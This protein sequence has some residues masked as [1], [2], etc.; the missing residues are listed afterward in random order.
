MIWII[1]IVAA[2]AGGGCSP[3]HRSVSETDI[4]KANKH[5]LIEGID[6]PR[7]RGASGCGSQA[8]GAMIAFANPGGAGLDAEAMADEL[9][10]H[11]EGATPVDLLLAA[12][13]R[14]CTAVIARGTIEALK[15]SIESGQ[16]IL[17]MLDAGLEVRSM[18]LGIRYPT[19]KVMHWAVVSGVAID[20]SQVLLAA[21]NRRHYIAS[22]ED[23]TRR[24]AKS[25]F[26]MISIA[27][28][29]GNVEIQSTRLRA[30]SE[31]TVAQDRC[32]MG[33]A[34]L[35]RL[36]KGREWTEEEVRGFQALDQEGKN[37]VVKQLAVEAGGIHTED[38]MGTDG[39]V[40]TA[41]WKE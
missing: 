38:Q 28:S 2:M 29:G 16:P 10:W 5:V 21:E 25:D 23:F 35:F 22:T 11:D 40:Y 33:F 7:V 4:I 30:S 12:R 24:W 3:L 19:P 34:E 41:F 1:L 26:C 17:V 14:G 37:R 32:S 36:A 15:A 31:P 20:D 13:H 27:A 18:I 6:V 8:L 39:V 9:P